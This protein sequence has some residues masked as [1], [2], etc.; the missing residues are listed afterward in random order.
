MNANGMTVLD[1]RLG[2]RIAAARQAA[3]LTQAALAR[4]LR[5]G[6]P[7]V[8]AWERGRR[9]PLTASLARLRAALKVPLTELLG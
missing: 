7:N 8:T 9:V 1:R 3:G 6:Q 2:K 5:T 4:K